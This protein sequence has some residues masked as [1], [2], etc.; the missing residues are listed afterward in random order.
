[1]S[2]SAGSAG[3]AERLSEAP[4]E[5]VGRFADASNA[6]LLARL[7]DRDP[8]S[9]DALS[10]ALGRTPALDDLDPRD[11]VVYKPE[12]GERPLW[13]FP[14]GTLHRREV[15][16]YEVSLALG[17]EQVPTTVRRTEGPF[18]HG[19]VQAFVVHDP[20]Q[21]YFTLQEAAT[22]AVAGQ[23]DRMVV[24]DALL[25][26]AD[27]KAGHVLLEDTEEPR[28]WLV[29]HGVCF[30]TEP[31]LRTVAWERAGEPIPGQLLADVDALR[32]SL[33]GDLAARLELLLTEQEVAALEARCVQLLDAACF[34]HPEVA[35]PYPWPLL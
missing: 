9:L 20:E 35:H 23:L 18:G 32:A 17:W 34:P 21:H 3:H 27:R 5:V 13:D 15:A 28:I 29:D 4:L 19:S 16:A 14:V 24:F 12:R 10:A 6:T 25:Q 7:T 30:H 2:T 33:A 11:L 26:N 31:K 22:A 1:M 8:R